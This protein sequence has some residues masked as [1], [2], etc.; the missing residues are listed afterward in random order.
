M[1]F[2]HKHF[3]CSRIQARTCPFLHCLFIYF[4]LFLYFIHV[5]SCRKLTYSR[6]FDSKIRSVLI[7][8]NPLFCCCLVDEVWWFLKIRHKHDKP[9]SSSLFF[10][11]TMISVTCL[12]LISYSCFRVFQGL[13]SLVVV[14]FT[15]INDMLVID[16]VFSATLCGRYTERYYHHMRVLRMTTFNSIV[17]I[18]P[19]M[20]C[21]L[22]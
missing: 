11:F 17:F 2:I 9:C 1:M 6:W 19:A 12:V 21:I 20:P 7:F 5:P 10:G 18:F 22:F 13:F 14:F 3:D 15:I 8:F 4:L 16:T